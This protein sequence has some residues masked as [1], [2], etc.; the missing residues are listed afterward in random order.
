MRVGILGAGISG[1]S[2]AWLLKQQGIEAT[3]LEGRGYIGGL[4]RSFK[5]HNFDCDFSAHRLFTLDENVLRQLLALVPMGRHIRRSQVYLGG[6]W[7]RDPINISEVALRFSPLLTTRLVWDYVRRPRDGQPR[8]FNQYVV[9]RYGRAMNDFVFRPYTERLFGLPGD[10]ISAEWAKQKIRLSGPSDILRE[11]S[12]KKFSYFYY[13]IR[14]GYGAIAQALYKQVQSQVQL[15]CIVKFLEVQEGRIIAVHSEQHGQTRRDEFDVLISTLPLT[16]LGY[17]LGQQFPLRFRGVDAVYLYV[18]QPYVSDNHWVY[19]MDRQNTIN[20]MVEFK[21]MSPVGLPPDY[22]V[23]CAEVTETR[24]DLIEAVVRDVVESGLL[25]R[26]AIL[27][28]MVKHEPFGY[29]VYAQ[30]YEKMVAHARECL[31]QFENL[32]L[33][34][35]SAEFEHKEVDDNF[36]TAIEVVQELL[37]RWKP[38]KLELPKEQTMVESLEQPLVYAVILTYNHVE[39]T[40]ECLQSLGAQTYKNMRG[41]VVDNGSKDNT[42][43]LVREQFPHVQVVET[44]QNLGVPW[45]YNIGF[46]IALEAGAT[47]VLMLNNDTILAPDLLENLVKA[48]ELDGAVGVAMP[49]VLYYDEPNIIWAAGGRWRLFPPAI[50]ILG[51]GKD[52]RKHM[53]ESQSLEFALSCGLLIHRQAFVKAGLFDPGYF[54]YFDDWDFSERVRANGLKILYVPMAKMWHKVS[55]TTRQSGNQAFFYQVWGE[56]AAR[57]YRRHG[58]PVSVM[59][60]LHLGYI[61]AREVIKG[62]GRM[63]KYFWAGV[64]SGLTKPL[65]RFPSVEDLHS[66]LSSIRAVRGAVD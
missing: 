66:Y 36:T 21:N 48:S 2:C 51:E 32:Y 65:G 35:R 30:E 13:P 24:S 50:V 10:Q 22:S 46:S 55:R 47:Y 6:K 58:R 54:F 37:R 8:S 52:E 7:L 12:K 4:A 5:W 31:R 29:P 49:K 57:F 3:L 25:R 20:R 38:I 63:L 34:G 56:S 53:V 39:D 15:N 23:L 62:N 16:I 60:P 45:G 27:D 28:A 26:D 42:P 18:N 59:L 40:L 43:A 11:S 19:F 1:L 61:M 33:V 41:L 9:Q 14:G 44:G 17:M 64:R